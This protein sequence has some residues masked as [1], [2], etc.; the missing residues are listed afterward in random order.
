MHASAYWL[1]DTLPR[2]LIQVIGHAARMQ[3]DTLRLRLV[4]IG[5]RVRERPASG[6]RIS[7]PE[8][9]VAQP[10]VDVRDDCH[11]GE[12]LVDRACATRS[13]AP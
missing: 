1:M 12:R 4:K 9:Y 7:F 2:W 13:D 6:R 3:L 11:L 10:R 5:A 8:A